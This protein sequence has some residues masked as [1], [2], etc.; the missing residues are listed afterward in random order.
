MTNIDLYKVL[1]IHEC[2]SP[3]V[4]KAAYKV[5]AQHYHPDKNVKDTSSIMANINSAYDTLSNP[6]KRTTYD[7]LVAAGLR[8]SSRQTIEIEEPTLKTKV[9]KIHEELSQWSNVFTAIKFL[10]GRFII[11]SVSIFWGYEL[12]LLVFKHHV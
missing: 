8:K 6:S 1:E 5:L 3:E 11:I 9:S 4:I 7:L 10:V 12:Y 2:A